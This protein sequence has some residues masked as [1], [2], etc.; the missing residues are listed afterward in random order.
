MQHDNIKPFHCDECGRSFAHRG[1]WLRHLKTH[2]QGVVKVGREHKE[3]V[4]K[5]GEFIVYLT[6]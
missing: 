5:P 2:Q 3:V 6:E 1:G 4:L